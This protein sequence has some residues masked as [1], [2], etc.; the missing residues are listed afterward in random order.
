MIEEILK[1]LVNFEH[2]NRNE[3][4]EFAK[5]KYEIPNTFKKGWNQ[6]KRSYK[7]QNR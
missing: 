3:V 7:W 4:I 1:M 6:I 5:G 2:Y